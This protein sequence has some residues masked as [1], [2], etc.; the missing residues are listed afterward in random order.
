MSVTAE[1][2]DDAEDAEDAEAQPFGGN[3]RCELRLIE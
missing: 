1:D 3:P 2:A